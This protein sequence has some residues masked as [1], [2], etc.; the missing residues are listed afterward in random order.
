MICYIHCKNTELLSILRGSFW[1]I[2]LP[3]LTAQKKRDTFA[4]AYRGVWH[5]L[6]TEWKKYTLIA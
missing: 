5:T 2:F 4:S 1:F 3:L 6:G